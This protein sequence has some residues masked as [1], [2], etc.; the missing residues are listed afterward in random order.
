MIS[1]RPKI[2][3]WGGIKEN[4]HNL[5]F[6]IL[7]IGGGVVL[8]EFR[9]KSFIQSFLLFIVGFLLHRMIGKNLKEL[10]NPLERIEVNLFVISTLILG[11]VLWL[12]S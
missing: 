7:V 10:R 9:M 11:M 5:Y 12:I 4:L 3:G 8:F 2:S 6:S 1:R